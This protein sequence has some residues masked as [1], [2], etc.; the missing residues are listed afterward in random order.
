[1]SGSGCEADIEGPFVKVEAIRRLGSVGDRVVLAV[2]EKRQWGWSNVYRVFPADRAPWFI[3]KMF[4]FLKEKTHLCE[5]TN[6]T[7]SLR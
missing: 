7:R 6:S 5:Q 3:R 4:S 2:I 1:M